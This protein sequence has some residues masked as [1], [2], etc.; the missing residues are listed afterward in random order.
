MDQFSK[1]FNFSEAEKEMIEFW[2]KN[3]TY[4][5]LLEKNKDGTV[6]RFMDGPPFVSSDKLHYGHVH[7]GCLKDTVLRYKRMRGY[8]VLNKIGYDTHGLPIEMVVNKML[9]INSKQDVE[10]LGV[11][12]YNAKCKE[13]INNF[14][15]SWNYI[16]D[17]IGRWVD[18]DNQYK[19]MDLKFMESTWWAFKQLWDKDL[20]YKGYKIMPY[21]T[22]C[23]TA[24]SNFEAGQNYKD[25]IDP[26]IY[27]KLK[28][29]EENKYFIVWTTTPWTLPSNLAICVNPELDYIEL[30]DDSTNN[31]Y[32]LAKDTINNLYPIPKKNKKSYKPPYKLINTFKGN[33]LIGTRYEPLFTYFS[34]DDNKIFRVIGDNFVTNESGTGVVHLAPSFG[35]DDLRVCIKNKVVDIT[36]IEKYCSV[37]DDGNFKELFKPYNGEYYS[38]VNRKV[39]EKLK[40]ENILIRKDMYKHSCPFC[41]RTDTPLIYKCVSSFFIKVTAIKDDLVSNNKSINWV[42]EYIGNKRFHNWLCDAKDWNVSRSRFFGTPIP[43]WISDDGEETVCV[44]SIEELAKLANLKNKDDLDDLHKEFID[45]IVISSKKGKGMLKSSGLVLDCWFESGVVPFAQNHYPFENSDIPLQ[46]DFVCEAVDQSRGWFYTLNVLSTAINNMPAFKNVICSGLLLGDDGTKFSKKLGNYKPMDILFNTYGADALRLYLGNSPASHGGSFKFEDQDIQIIKRKL[47]QFFN[48]VKFFIENYI[49]YIKKTSDNKLDQFDN[50]AYKQSNNIMDKWIISRLGTLSG[51]IITAMDEYR[52]YK[53]YP[54][55]HDF[56]EDLT[57]WYIKFNRGRLKGRFCSQVEE[58][59]ALSTLYY[60]LITFCKISAPFMPFLTEV[61]YQKLKPI[62]SNNKL[63][64]IHHEKFPLPTDFLI[65]TIAERQ[66]K[67]M[68]LVSKAVRPLRNL[69]NHANSIRVPI[70]TV[71]IYTNDDEYIND[72]KYFE[73]YMREEINALDI[74]Y[75]KIEDSMINYIPIPNKKNIGTKYRKLAPDIIRGISNLGQDSLKN[76]MKNKNNGLRLTINDIE[77]LIGFEDL[78]IEY[79]L[80]YEL[81][82]QERSSVNDDFIV[83]CNF[84]YDDDVKGL[85]LRKLFT[86][87][88]Q[89]LRKNTSLKPWNKIKIYYDTKDENLLK[90]IEKYRKVIVE[91]L[92]Y[93]IYQLSSVNESEEIVTSIDSQLENPFNQSDN[94]NLRIE[95]RYPVDK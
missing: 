59:Q 30:I 24:L 71:C 77:Y 47:I 46:A 8:N 86:R 3:D 11:D 79:K 65:D 18:Y 32:I 45:Q 94:I 23:N 14:S 56:I 60:T 93:E 43:V 61:I 50:N 69:T 80:N 89:D 48:C 54:E 75:Y 68:Q 36:E 22:K 58:M 78:D 40:D 57:N 19:T 31:I 41:W 88:I 87:T 73:R 63:E 90:I 55:L 37:D 64:S 15:N 38:E 20:V 4:K 35:E 16:Y 67:R 83:I 17:R 70:K 85:F 25:V 53:I 33:D 95:I 29:K 82:D 13:V 5:K 62:D 44:G 52:I 6:F 34:A 21:S 42:P 39:I 2:K 92:I 7:I 26:S 74:K 84:E 66:M 51:N 28:I 9:N 1:D 12:K 10:K 27:F 72:L 91:E 76:L 81:A 49:R